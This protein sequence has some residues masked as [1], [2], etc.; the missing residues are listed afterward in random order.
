MPEE[1]AAMPAKVKRDYTTANRISKTV[2]N[3]LVTR[4]GKTGK[5]YLFT[6]LH[7]SVHQWCDSPYLA[8]RR[9]MYP[10][11]VFAVICKPEHPH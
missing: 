1:A 6:L 11:P 2:L 5:Q 8:N 10:D 9:S 7:Q 4:C 3:C